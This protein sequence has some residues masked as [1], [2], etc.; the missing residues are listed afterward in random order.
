MSALTLPFD[1]LAIKNVFRTFTYFKFLPILMKGYYQI[2]TKGLSEAIDIY[3]QAIEQAP[4]F[5]PLYCLLGDIYR[6]IGQYDDAIM[7]INLQFG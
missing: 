1:N 5:V 2:Q 6:S 4:G 3:I 7:N